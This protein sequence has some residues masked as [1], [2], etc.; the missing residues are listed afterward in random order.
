MALEK[1]KSM[2]FPL[3]T[4]EIT[5]VSPAEKWKW[6]F[7]LGLLLGSRC[8]L[9][10]LP[11]EACV[12]VHALCKCVPCSVDKPVDRTLIQPGVEDNLLQTC[13]SSYRKRGQRSREQLVESI[14]Q[15]RKYISGTRI[16][17]GRGGAVTR[18]L[19]GGRSPS[20]LAL[21][22]ESSNMMF[23]IGRHSTLVKVDR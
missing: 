11:T 2:F 4:L 21:F 17:R 5:W 3:R 12:C 1:K 20:W 9:R 15:S 8:P 16:Q 6:K 23:T 22:G 10:C 7:F 19:M 18:L 14:A 13:P